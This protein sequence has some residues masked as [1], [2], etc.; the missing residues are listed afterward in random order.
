MLRSDWVFWNWYF[1][2]PLWNCFRVILGPH[3]GIF[4][5]FLYF[6]NF[7]VFLA[8]FPF[9]WSRVNGRINNRVKSFYCKLLE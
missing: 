3:G 2:G 7:A 5:V 1:G 6:G 9:D 4:E 8:V